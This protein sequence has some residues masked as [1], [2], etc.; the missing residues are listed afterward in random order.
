ML[1]EVFKYYE[2]VDVAI[3][4]AA[5]ADYTPKY[6]SDQKIKRRNKTL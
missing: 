2:N 6:Y 1:E 3:M 4:S 5:V